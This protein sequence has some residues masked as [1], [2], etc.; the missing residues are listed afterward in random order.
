MNLRTCV[1]THK[2]SCTNIMHDRTNTGIPEKLYITHS[3]FEFFQSYPYYS[4]R[5]CVYMRI[6]I[7]L[8]FLKNSATSFNSSG[9]I[10]SV[11]HLTAKVIQAERGREGGRDRERKREKE[12]RERKK[13][14]RKKRGGERERKRERERQREREKER[15][16]KKNKE[17]KKEKKRKKKGERTV[18]KQK[19]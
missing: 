4:M 9:P 16:K 5:F 14:K 3:N 19:S 6:L 15:E 12:E 18:R 10:A 13:K 7:T 8:A 17:R 2:Q 11:A 1:C